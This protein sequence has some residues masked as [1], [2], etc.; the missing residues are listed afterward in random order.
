MNI[1]LQDLGFKYPK[2]SMPALSAISAV[3]SPGMHLLLGENG[4]GKT[5]LLHLISGLLYPTEGRCLVDGC[6]TK[7]RLPS[8]NSHI[9]FTGV[10]MDYPSRSINEMA[11]IHGRFYP[12]F[13]ALQLRE[14]LESF[15]M[16]GNEKLTSLSLGNAQK[17]KIA[18]ALA[19]NTDILLLDEPANGL[20]IESKRV[21]QKLIADRTQPHQTVIVSTHTV[22]DLEHLYD[23]VID[24]RGGRLLYALSVD[25]IID[26]IRFV[27]ADSVPAEAIYSEM[28]VGRHHCIIPNSTGAYTDPDYQLLYMAM[29]TPVSNDL[30]Y[31]LLNNSRQ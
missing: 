6:D 11:S 23:G 22:A 26:R 2:S 19:L 4:A 14:N 29:R 17:A 3:I 15:N 7:L 8:V 5:T 31:S 1:E 24:L 20:D 18:Y 25:E 21:M 28:R 16:N 13:S 9:F 12:T 27:V 10:G 30:I